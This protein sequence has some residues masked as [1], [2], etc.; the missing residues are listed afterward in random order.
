MNNHNHETKQDGQSQI[1]RPDPANH[2]VNGKGKYACPTTYNHKYPSMDQFAKSIGLAIKSV[3][4]RHAY[5]RQV[6]LLMEFFER[7][8]AELNETDLREYFLFLMIDKKWSPSTMR[9]AVAALKRFYIDML[10]LKPWDVFS[11][12]NTKD[13][14]T[15]PACP[16]RMEIIRLL[17][18]FPRQRYLTPTKLIYCC[19]LRLSEA[20]SLTVHDIKR[21]ER[22]LFIH[23]SKGHR[24][25]IVPVAAKMI[26]ELAAYW[27]FHQ[28]P[29]L[30]FPTTGN[31]CQ[32]P[33]AVAKRMHEATEPICR[34]SFEGA[35][36]RAGKSI[37]VRN[38]TLRNLRHSFGTHFCQRGGNLLKLQ[39]IMGH[40]NIETTM[41]YLH[42]THEIDVA[43]MDLVEDIFEALEPDNQSS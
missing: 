6:R 36:S 25:R 41:L 7:D 1:N 29:L 21:E 22:K 42:I 11:E 9:Q 10:K 26:D 43:S 35:V 32:K 15:K 14:Y 39:K 2:N 28:N 23:N 17:S 13:N 18:A 5:Y 24:D 40:K 38:C 4:S 20:L 8:P 37:K 12:V 31:G 3:R 33:E 34:T 30:I 27:R 19:G 16:T